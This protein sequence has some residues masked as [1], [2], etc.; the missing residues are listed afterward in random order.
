MVTNSTLAPEELTASKCRQFLCELA[1]MRAEDIPAALRIRRLFPSVV[2]CFVDKC[3]PADDQIE[4]YN[5][6]MRAWLGLQWLQGLVQSIWNAPTPL[7]RGDRLII[8]QRILSSRIAGILVAKEARVDSPPSSLERAM[9]YFLRH[10]DQAR[11]CPNPT[12]HSPYFLA[13]HRG[14]KYCS[15]PCA[16]PAQKEFKAQWWA[17]HGKKLRAQ[18]SKSKRRSK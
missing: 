17:K 4:G 14:R 7:A 15:A 2:A 10:I 16:A 6:D 3:W 1:N 12:C 13:D 9:S 11:I 5:E 8:M 18:K